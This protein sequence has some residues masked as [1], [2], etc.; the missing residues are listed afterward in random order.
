MIMIFMGEKAGLELSKKPCMLELGL[1]VG[2]ELRKS[3]YIGSE[4]TG[5]TLFASLGSCALC[6][7]VILGAVTKQQRIVSY[8]SSVYDP[9]HAMMMIMMIQR[10]REDPTTTTQPSLAGW[11]NSKSDYTPPPPRLFHSLCF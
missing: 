1:E 6:S 8:A 4:L 7:G 11:M 2:T 5:N 3:T 9:D 10:K